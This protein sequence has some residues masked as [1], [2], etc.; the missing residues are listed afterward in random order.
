MKNK[1]P[2]HF[3][4]PACSGWGKVLVVPVLL[5]AWSWR[6]EPLWQERALLPESLPQTLLSSPWHCQPALKQTRSDL[7][8]VAPGVPPQS[9]PIPPCSDHWH[10]SHFYWSELCQFEHQN[11]DVSLLT[12]HIPGHLLFRFHRSGV[13]PRIRIHNKLPSDIEAAAWWTMLR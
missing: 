10:L 1:K 4:C 7:W 9:S 8:V 5:E 11:L 3:Q 6:E 13:R 2:C 12:T